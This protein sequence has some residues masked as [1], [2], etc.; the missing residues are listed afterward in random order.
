MLHTILFAAAAASVEIRGGVAAATAATT[1]CESDLDCQLNGACQ[2]ANDAAS[3]PH[4]DA[5]HVAGETPRKK[6]CVCDKG[7][8]GPDCGLL[9]IATTPTI[10]YGYGTT[11]KTSSWGGGPPAYDNATGMYHLFMSEI[12]GNCGMTTW[13]HMSRGAHAVS[14]TAEGPYT[15]V[16]TII[17]TEAH[18]IFYAYSPSD[19]MHLLYHIFQGNNPESC[20]PYFPC[21]NGSTPGATGHGLKPPA[22]WNH[23]TCAPNHTTSVHYSKSLNGPWDKVDLT[24]DKSAPPGSGAHFPP[25]GGNSNPAPWVLPNGTVLMLSRGKDM[26]MTGNDGEGIPKNRNIVLFR[27]DSWNSTYRWVPSNGPNGTVNIGD[28]KVTTEDPVLWKGRRG[29]HALLHSSPDMTHG[30]SLDGI[31][32]DWSPQ[33]I[34]PP[35]LQGDNERPRAVIDDNGDLKTIMCGQLCGPGDAAR[36]AA[37]PAL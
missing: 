37:F 31:S 23:G 2:V 4:D 24:F 5:V 6:T 18:N 10:A 34:G 22:G 33:I 26:G 17:E 30:W 19:Q 8:K 28:G 27:A 35:T 9:N 25:H 7:W 12:A 11:P 21:T 13:A 15:R 20:N 14:K 29:F 32:W 16:E 1:R 36:T 3:F